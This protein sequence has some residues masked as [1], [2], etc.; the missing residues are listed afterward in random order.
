MYIHPSNYVSALGYDGVHQST[1]FA[2]IGKTYLQFLSIFSLGYWEKS[3]NFIIDHAFIGKY[4][5]I[6]VPSCFFSFEGGKG[7]NKP[8]VL[9]TCEGFSIVNA[10]YIQIFELLE[11]NKS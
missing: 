3:K 2:A 11:F 10:F 5:R 6:I 4:K 9:K 1:A 7:W 8:A